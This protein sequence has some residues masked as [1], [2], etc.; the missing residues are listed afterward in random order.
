MVDG[1]EPTYESDLNTRIRNY[2]VVTTAALPWMTGTGVNPLLRAGYL[3]RRNME[4]KMRKKK[5]QEEKAVVEG[6]E[7]VFVDANDA[8]VVE[9][10]A[11]S[12][13]CSLDYSC[14]TME[15]EAGEKNGLVT[16]GE[17][18]LIVGKETEGGVTGEVTLVVP[19]LVDRS[20]REMLYGGNVFEDMDEQEVFIR[21]WLSV[22]AGM[23]MEAK[24]LK[25]L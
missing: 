7:G 19:W 23:T 2:H 4:L 13:C 16:S 15:D 21:E 14:F 9:S 22:D 1:D 11:E 8:P 6:M 17:K 24:E 18:E 25:I 20:E 5:Q 10:E 3:V 12:S